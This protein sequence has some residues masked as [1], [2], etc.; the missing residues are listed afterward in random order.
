VIVWALGISCSVTLCTSPVLA[1]ECSRVDWLH[2]YIRAR[3][4]HHPNTVFFSS[5]YGLEV[6]QVA[7]PWA[8]PPRTRFPDT[9]VK[10]IS[11]DALFNRC[12][13]WAFTLALKLC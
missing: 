4:T 11:G 6:R 2:G 7:H 13:R 12:G 8:E 3:G 10:E 5:P 1:S 9:Y